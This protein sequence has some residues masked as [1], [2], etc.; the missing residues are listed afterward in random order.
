MSEI[1]LQAIVE[2]LEALEIALKEMN[3]GKNEEFKTA[4]KSVQ[5]ELIKFSS[6]F[7]SNN[8]N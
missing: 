3:A 8:E 2:K 4:V 7:T 5:S 1:L 6:T